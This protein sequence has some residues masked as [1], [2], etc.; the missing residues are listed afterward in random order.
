MK[1]FKDYLIQKEFSENTI[2][3]Y[4]NDI[5]EFLE[6][7]TKNHYLMENIC[8][9]DLM[10]YI[11]HS[12]KQGRSKVNV[13]H[14]LLAMRHYFN[15][16]VKTGKIKSNPAQGVYVRGIARR[17]PHDL[18]AYSELIKV[19]ENYP[20]NDIRSQRNKVILG[21]FIFQALTIE[22]LETLEPEHI[23]LREGKIKIIGTERTNERVLKLE[24]SQVFELQEYL[25]KTRNRI[26][27]GP[28]VNEPEKIK[29]LIIGM[30]GATR[31]PAEVGQMMRKLKHPTI[32]QASQIR[33]SVIAEWTKLHDVRIVQ[34]MSG[35]KYVSTTERYQA[36][37][38]EDLQEQLRLHH[39]LK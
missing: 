19:Y 21:L 25:N 27:Y 28:L 12:Q 1:T 16:Q 13:Q 30:E 5:K 10:N 31:L 14:Q 9:A 35:H 26:L 18:T 6:W 11:K 29:Q 4:E 20:V 24:A 17:L 38:L 34:Y 32:K 36:T 7:T 22:E 39:P 3:I 37:H 33:A 2:R 8:Y 15:Y 23:S